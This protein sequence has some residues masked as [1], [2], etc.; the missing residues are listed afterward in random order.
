MPEM[1]EE[2]PEG[3]QRGFV[4]PMT[5]PS[6]A[7]TSHLWLQKNIAIMTRI[8]MNLGKFRTFTTLVISK[9]NPTDLLHIAVGHHLQLSMEMMSHAGQNGPYDQV[10]S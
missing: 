9:H 5:P 6:A 3:E 2:K 8:D 10:W 4:D 1:P 7:T